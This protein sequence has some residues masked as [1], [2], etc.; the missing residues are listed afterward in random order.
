MK[1]CSVALRPH[2]TGRR[3]RASHALPQ[4]ACKQTA[5]ARVDTLSSVGHRRPVPFASITTLAYAAWPMR[6]TQQHT[7]D[8]K[9]CSESEETNSSLCVC[10]AQSLVL[11]PL[12]VWLELLFVLGY[13]PKLHADLLQSIEQNVATVDQSKQPL[14]EEQQTAAA[15]AVSADKK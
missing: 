3:A 8:G 13:R 12:F 15:T 5:P 11:A 1:L 2:R 9:V 4:A 6:R 7:H 10:C 14:L